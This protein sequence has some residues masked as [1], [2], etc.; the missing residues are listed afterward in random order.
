[1]LLMKPETSSFPVTFELKSNEGGHRTQI[2]YAKR[3]RD[4]IFEVSEKLCRISRPQSVVNVN[5]QE[6]NGLI[7]IENVTKNEQSVIELTVLNPSLSRV[8]LNNLY[9]MRLACLSP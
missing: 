6:T 2:F 1:M 4:L 3:L 7:S 8:A 9:H 5:C